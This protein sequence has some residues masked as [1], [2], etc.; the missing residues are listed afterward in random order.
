MPTPGRSVIA[1]VVCEHSEVPEVDEQVAADLDAAADLC[2]LA[3]ARYLTFAADLPPD[4]AAKDSP[5]KQS[6]RLAN[7]QYGPSGN[8]DESWVQ[9][10][11]F[12]SEVYL[13][14]A[15]QHLT[16]IAAL[17]R[18]REVAFPIAPLARSISEL[19]ARIVWLLD[20]RSLGIRQRCARAVLDYV[21]ST[22]REKQAAV[23][24]QHRQASMIGQKYHYVRKVLP[25]Q[26][27]DPSEIVI[28]PSGTLILSK[29]RLLGPSQMVE[30]SGRIVDS[31][32]AKSTY[33][34]LS[35]HVH[36][37]IFAIAE[38][39]HTEIDGEVLRHEVRIEDADFPT[40]LTLNAVADFQRA[41]RQL[42]SWLMA[43]LDEV[44]EVQVAHLKLQ[45]KLYGRTGV[46]ND[47]DRSGA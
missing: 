37:T 33:D 42:T 8:W 13:L 4:G 27:F 22:L 34:F 31:P 19:S 21:D 44:D 25:A 1:S 17:L 41:W 40:K 29:Q 28:S 26:L 7:R 9:T 24:F 43:G 14:A 45:D 36:P 11:T 2:D 47:D 12:H 5:F 15:S 16:G 10:A 32:E 30:E 3:Y 39:L 35:A 46:T 23:A 6:C 18:A 38:M 20:H